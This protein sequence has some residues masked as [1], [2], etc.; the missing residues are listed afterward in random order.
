ML[1]LAILFSKY[2]YNTHFEAKNLLLSRVTSREGD[3]LISSKYVAKSSLKVQNVIKNHLL[4]SL[5]LPHFQECIL[6]VNKF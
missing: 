4:K 6:V 5:L 3:D 1:T 2:F